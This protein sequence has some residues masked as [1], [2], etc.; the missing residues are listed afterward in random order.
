MTVYEVDA[1]GD[2]TAV[3]RGMGGSV[4]QVVFSKTQLPP[5][6]SGSLLC[7][8]LG[9]QSECLRTTVVQKQTLYFQ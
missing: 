1:S 6:N 9:E 7:P 8:S 3:V 4:A 5:A 2:C